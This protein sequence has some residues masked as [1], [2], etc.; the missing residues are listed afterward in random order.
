M[1]SL[2]NGFLVYSKSYFEYDNGANMPIK[3]PKKADILISFDLFSL[4]S[5]LNLFLYYYFR[6]YRILRL[7]VIN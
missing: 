1:I 7:T 3:N 6:Y 2:L 4:D 5:S